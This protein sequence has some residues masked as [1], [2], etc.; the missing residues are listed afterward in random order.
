MKHIK[1]IAVLV[2]GMMLFSCNDDFLNP[3]PDSVVVVDQFF[4]NDDDVLAGIIGI[5][6]A[7]QGVNEDTETNSSNYNRGVQFEYL[8]TEMRTDN[9]RSA[10]TEGSKADF[11]RYLVDAN[12]VEVEDYYASSY[13]IIFRAN[14]VLNYIEKA[15]A[16]NR[17]SYTAE[18]KFLR[19]YAYFNLVRLFGDVPLITSVVG[20]EE[21][22]VLFTRVSTS[23]IYT[24]IIED[25]Q[26]AILNLNST[27]KSRASTAAAQALL[28][29][30]YLTKQSPDY[31]G[32]QQLCESIIQSMQFSLMPNFHDVYYSELNDE[33]LFAIG[34]VAGNTAESQGFSSEFTTSVGRQDGLNVINDNLI[35]DFG[36]YGGDRTAESYITV[37]SFYE[38]AKFL[39]NGF[40]LADNYGPNPRQAGNDWIVSRYADVL[41][42]HVEAIMAGGT[43]TTVQAARDSFNEVRLRANMPTIDAPDAITKQD[44]INERR[45]EL[46]FENHRFFDLV[47]F[48]IANSVLSAHA[49][50]MDYTFNTRDLL[51]P[52]P[53]R[54]INIS[55]GLL[56]QNPGY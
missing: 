10:T 51:L 13:E 31:L 17:A 5:Y 20:P 9:T 25:L 45:V 46:A 52:I 3:T 14:T 23:T 2:S 42:M 53:A 34:Y 19:A 38:V 33:I 41:L 36:L 49:T 37:G 4:N 50:E 18:A 12:N 28:A 56:S 55:N 24:V 26:E 39:P 15:D 30:V 48:G 47:R 6:D 43:Q 29:K 21:T 16:A 1:Y 22:D 8:L 11:H 40:G 44:L 7:I 54:E 35:A 27:Y 32:A